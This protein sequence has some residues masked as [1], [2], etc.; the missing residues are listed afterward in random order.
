[1]STTNET[2]PLFGGKKIKGKTTFSADLDSGVL[3]VR[4]V[5]ATI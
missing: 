5:E 3:V 4:Q 2:C 1:M